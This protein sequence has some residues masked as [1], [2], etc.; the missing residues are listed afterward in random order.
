M[1]HNTRGSLTCGR[2]LLISLTLDNE[3]NQG[4]LAL[5]LASTRFPNKSLL[6]PVGRKFLHFTTSGCG[7]GTVVYKWPDNHLKIF[8]GLPS[9][10]LAGE[11]A[12][13]KKCKAKKLLEQT[14]GLS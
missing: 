5:W 8:T 4:F 3:G 11:V 6:T 12:V 9:T 14:I 1:V 7:G 13:K 2:N 10:R